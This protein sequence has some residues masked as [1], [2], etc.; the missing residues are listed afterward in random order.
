MAYPEEHHAHIH[1]TLAKGLRNH[2]FNL[3]HISEA[4]NPGTLAKFLKRTLEN[5]TI[6]DEVPVLALLFSAWMHTESLWNNSRT[7]LICTRPKNPE[8]AII[9]LRTARNVS[10]LLA[11]IQCDVSLS[12]LQRGL[13]ISDICFKRQVFDAD[14][15]LKGRDILSITLSRHVL[16]TNGS[17]TLADLTPSERQQAFIDL[18]AF[19]TRTGPSVMPS[20]S[21]GPGLSEFPKFASGIVF[22]VN[23]L[24]NTTV[25]CDPP[26][27]EE[28]APF[29]DTTE[30]SPAPTV[31]ARRN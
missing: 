26:F 28:P 3:Q 8:H 18:T 17:C 23:G 2:L 10:A 1:T 24:P 25:P 29:R 22:S 11:P 6:G 13:I 21:P 19:A 12:E 16:Q 31:S 27:P 20:F 7:H 15:T 30:P 9:D 4:G 5:A 14:I